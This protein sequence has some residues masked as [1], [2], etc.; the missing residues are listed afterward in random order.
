MAIEVGTESAP[1]A[2]PVA[3]QVG[4]EEDSFEQR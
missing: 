1:I 2:A 3:A 4:Q